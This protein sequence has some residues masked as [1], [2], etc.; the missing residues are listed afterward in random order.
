MRG[1]I[2]AAGRGSRLGA[3]TDAAPKCTIIVNGRSLLDRQLQSMRL[4]G[5]NEI[6]AVTGY[7]SQEISHR[8]DWTVSNPRWDKTNIAGSLYCADQILS[9]STTVISYGDIFYPTSAVK[10]LMQ[11]SADIALI[12]DPNWLTLWEARFSD[13]YSD[14]E[15][16]Q[17]G[18]SQPLSK[19][20]GSGIQKS[21]HRMLGKIGG[22]ASRS[23][24]I[25]GQYIGL[26]RITAQGWMAI[27]SCIAE[28]TGMESI[29]SLDMTSLFNMLI[30]N[31]L[32]ISAIPLEGIWG[33]VDRPEDIKLYEELYKD[34]P[35]F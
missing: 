3:L 6:G 10:S 20:D 22:R 12:Y 4:A 31:G 7:M 19:F 17:F 26:F 15:N 16:F 21:H 11:S 23:D 33:E 34:I 24:H 32:Q 27:K 14:A 2:L 1:L 9:T 18:D 29:N 30:E 25:D 28:A 8:F 35:N 13:P 5:L